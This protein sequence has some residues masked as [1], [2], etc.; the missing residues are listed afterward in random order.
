MD[1][2]AKNTDRELYREPDQ[3]NGSFYSDSIH[4]TE[5]GS[6]GM[7]HGG[8]VIVMPIHRWHYFA[9]QALGQ[10]ARHANGEQPASAATVVGQSTRPES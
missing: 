2:C 6:I 8:Y 4:V 1:N 7:N 9:K 5:Y 3:G 10:M